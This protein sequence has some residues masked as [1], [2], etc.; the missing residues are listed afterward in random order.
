[1][2]DYRAGG[3]KVTVAWM[4]QRARKLGLAVAVSEHR[5]QR[6]ED[7][8]DLKHAHGAG[9]A[10]PERVKTAFDPAFQSVMAGV[11]CS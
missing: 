10:V 2:G 8:D 4:G 9:A 7:R 11:S 3:Q 5:R 6:D 1:M